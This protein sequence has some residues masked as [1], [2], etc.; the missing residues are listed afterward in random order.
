MAARVAI[1]NDTAT[2]GHYGCAAVMDMLSG[3]LRDAGAE[4]IYRHP[5]GTEWRDVVVAEQAI[6]AADLVLVNGE[7]TIHHATPRARRLSSLGPYCADLGKRC[8][9]LNST[10][11]DNDDA[12][13]AEIARF[14]HVWVRESASSAEMR[15]AGIGHTVCFD[16][17][18]LKA[19]PAAVVREGP[20]LF[21]DSVVSEVAKRLAELARGAGAALVVMKRDET[22]GF[23]MGWPPDVLAATVG[24]KA[25]KTPLWP[26]ADAD[27]F[28]LLLAGHDRIL[29][30][31]FH[32]M[33]F[34]IAMRLPFHVYASNSHKVEAT[35]QDMGLDPRRLL[36]LSDPMP[37][38]LPF[39]ASERDAIAH[40]LASVR[41]SAADMTARVLA[42]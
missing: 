34:A 18:L 35:L 41:S 15:A 31:R 40:A 39:S 19:Y 23:C 36:S 29:T 12:I 30:G 25:P 14:D 33:C 10:L 3:L 26:C 4:V 2:S 1:F 38:L 32:A 28:A 5:V 27:A 11:Q 20:V 17:S 13:N 7:G 9:L 22:S 42:Y 8:F 37:D 21:V 6:A 24:L 16:L